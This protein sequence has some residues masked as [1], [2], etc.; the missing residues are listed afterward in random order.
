MKKNENIFIYSL[1]ILVHC[2]IFTQEVPT[3]HFVITSDEAVLTT[4]PH[5][6]LGDPAPRGFTFYGDKLGDW[7]FIEGKGFIRSRDLSIVSD[8][9]IH[10]PT[11]GPL[12]PLSV[13][14][15]NGNFTS[16][17]PELKFDKKKPFLTIYGFRREDSTKV[18]SWPTIYRGEISNQEFN[19][20]QVGGFREFIAI[21][22]WNDDDFDDFIFTGPSLNGAGIVPGIWVL[23]S[24]P[25]GY[26]PFMLMDTEQWCHCNFSTVVNGWPEEPG[27][28]LMY[29]EPARKALRF[30][31][32]DAAFFV[33]ISQEGEWKVER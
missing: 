26:K 19:F 2:N 4:R 23:L 29:Y 30:R 17:S 1:L 18:D 25:K 24:N 9:L 13:R 10:G 32:T 11:T 3:Q 14:T 6:T 5:D 15:P 28:S 8:R 27:A 20:E 12:I 21:V 22:D 7:V 33:V 16:F 31:H